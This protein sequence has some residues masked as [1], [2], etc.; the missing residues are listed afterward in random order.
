[1]GNP[2]RSDFESGKLTSYLLMYDG[3]KEKSIGLGRKL[4]DEI[5]GLY[6][7]IIIFAI[8]L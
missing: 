3:I 8:Y 5:L 1:L 7:K 4:N 2:Y 6:N